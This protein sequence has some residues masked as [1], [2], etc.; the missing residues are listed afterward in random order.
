MDT[1]PT[2]RRAALALSS[3]LVL[4]LSQPT[5][6][7]TAG[8]P[9][10][11]VFDHQVQYF[12]LNTATPPVYVLCT[13]TPPGAACVADTTGY[14]VRVDGAVTQTVPLSANVGGTVTVQVPAGLPQGNHGVVAEA[15]G[16]ST[17]ASAAIAL[18]V[19]V[20]LPPAPGPQGAPVLT[21]G[22]PPIPPVS[23]AFASYSFNAGSGT[24]V[25]DG[26]GNGRNGTIT[27]ATWVAGKYGQALSFDGN[28]LVT[29]GDLDLPASF[30]VMGWFQTRVLYPGTCGS[31]VM[32]A[33]DYGFELCGSSFGAK[34]ASG[35]SWTTEI[36]K[37]LTSADLNVWH[38][39]AMTYDG[40][41][42][43]FYY[44]GVLVNQ[45]SGTHTTN[46]TPLFFGRWS[47]SG[48]FWHGL[49][50]EVRLYTK[51]L[52]AAEIVA[53]MGRPLP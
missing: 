40:A 10:R 16:S 15:V 44:D 34:V 11:V 1:R 32:K 19:G 46:N 8:E 45:G 7:L 20:G 52:T 50:D 39:A 31:F 30:T 4:A 25:A 17:V 23:G 53:D 3:V 9:F 22:A 43:R 48:E 33:F 5:P 13:T 49:I 18:P 12:Q 14:Q 27:G 35:S 38:H 24:T 2:M 47:T 21:R 41:V 26:S 6:P 28:D 42:L 37:T 51:V 36:A 29:F